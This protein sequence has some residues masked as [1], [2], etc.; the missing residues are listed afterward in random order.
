MF[1]LKFDFVGDNMLNDRYDFLR[2]MVD[3]MIM[4]FVFYMDLKCFF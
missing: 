2:F 4:I 3:K 1:G